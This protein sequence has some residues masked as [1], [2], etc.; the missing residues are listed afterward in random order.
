MDWMSCLA[1]ATVMR[2]FAAMNGRSRLGIESSSRALAVP[3]PSVSY[4]YDPSYLRLSS[5]TDGIGT[6]LYSYYPITP[7]P[8]L[9]AGKLAST[10]G[11][12][13][14]TETV[15]YAYDELGRPVSREINGVTS[16]VAFDA[17]GRMKQETNALGTFSE[18]IGGEQGSELLVRHQNLLGIGLLGTTAFTARAAS[19]Y[20]VLPF[21]GAICPR[22]PDLAA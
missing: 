17:G 15:S 7:V 9:G 12:P 21:D 1:R 20:C 8:R 6:T 10:K 11:G 22:A 18:P 5:M 16:S 4:T 13:L 3:T 14:F 2:S 19:E